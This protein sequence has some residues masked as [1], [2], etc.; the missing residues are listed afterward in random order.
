[1]NKVQRSKTTIR[2]IQVSRLKP[3]EASCGIWQRIS[4][5]FPLVYGRFYFTFLQLSGF[6]SANRE[7]ICL[8]C[9]SLNNWT[10]MATKVGFSV[11]PGTF[12]ENRYFMEAIYIHLPNIAL[13]FLSDLCN[14]SACFHFIL[15]ILL[16]YNRKGYS[17][18]ASV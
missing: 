17:T 15:F 16:T 1:M 4:D 2:N 12:T 13:L 8:L 6:Y 3:C 9:L 18:F 5:E 10:S 7:A 14:R 11:Q